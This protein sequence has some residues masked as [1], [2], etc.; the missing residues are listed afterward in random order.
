MCDYITIHGLW[1]MVWLKCQGC[2]RNMV[3]KVV[4]RKSGK[5][6]PLRMGKN[7]KVCV[8][9]VNAH[10]WITQQRMILIRDQNDLLCRHQ[11]ASFPTHPGHLPMGSKCFW[12]CFSENKENLI[13][14][15]LSV[16]KINEKSPR[17]SSP[18]IT[19]KGLT[20]YQT[21][22]QTRQP[23]T[24][25][26]ILAEDMTLLGQ[27][28]RAF[29]QHSKQHELRIHMVLLVP[30][31]PR[32]QH[33]ATRWMRHMLWVCVTAKKTSLGKPMILQQASNKPAQTLHRRVT[34]SL[35]CWIKPKERYTISSKAVVY[36]N[37]FEKIIRM[38]GYQCLSPQDTQKC[39]RPMENY[40]PTTRNKEK[41]LNVSTRKEQ[42]Y[43]N[44]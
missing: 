34:P 28:Q 7:M 4:T 15:G 23:A 6:R 1:A 13:T 40:L 37:I 27:R 31:V 36:T 25:S 44:F 21:C 10:K 32:G 20:F 41:I 43:S 38:K 26:Q 16:L 11:S 35:L 29:L 39:Q 8:S 9:C 17:Q 22:K 30:Q 14:K 18:P 42:V 5:D 3:G 33:R 19:M 2:R 12:F 24:V